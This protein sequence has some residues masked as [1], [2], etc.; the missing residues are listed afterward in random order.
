MNIEYTVAYS[1]AYPA[2]TSLRVV[3]A[4]GSVGLSVVRRGRVGEGTDGTGTGARDATRAVAACQ[5]HGTA[6]FERALVGAADAFARTAF[7]CL[8]GAG[9]GGQ[10]ALG[11]AALVAEN[12]VVA[13]LAGLGDAIAAHSSR[14]VFG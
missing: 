2:K 6:R 9:N 1:E 5:A 11:G 14:L 3:V 7:V 8:F 13:F 4:V 12:A 10:T